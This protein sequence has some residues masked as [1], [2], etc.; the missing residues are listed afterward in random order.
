M[1][2]FHP[3]FRSTK[4]SRP[5]SRA[6]ALMALTGLL[7]TTSLSCGSPPADVENAA[8]PTPSETQTPPPPPP[9]SPAPP[10]TPEVRQTPP[11]R[12]NPATPVTPPTQ[13]P[14]TPP[15]L[16]GRGTPPPDDRYTPPPDE[17]RRVSSVFP[18]SNEAGDYASKSDHTYWK[19]VDPDPNGLNCRMSE[20]SI[21]EV[22]SATG[23]PIDIGNWPV[24][25]T[26]QTNQE[27]EAELS[28]GGFVITFD[29]QGKPW[30]Y[31]ES[32]EGN[33]TSDCFVRA[34]T[35]YVEPIRK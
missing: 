2:N 21:D 14:G 35:Q 12:A 13:P 4:L 11:P 20:A 9:D 16:E 1:M 33:G 15:P 23:G 18:R 27:F 28:P 10:A 22:W 8:S 29:P 5:S 3:L 6:I 24:V 30:I 26:L 17:R 31:V 32:S 34:N 7:A 25:G 19:V